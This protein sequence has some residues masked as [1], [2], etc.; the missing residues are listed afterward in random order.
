MVKVFL[1]LTACTLFQNWSLSG[2]ICG[3]FINQCH[4][5]GL[6]MNAFVVYVKED[7]CVY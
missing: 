4:R 5:I 7:L 1:E 2:S 6:A 3:T